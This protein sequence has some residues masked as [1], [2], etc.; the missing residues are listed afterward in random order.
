MNQK[1]EHQFLQAKPVWLKGRETEKNLILGF[2]KCFDKPQ[3]K[4]VVVKIAAATIYRAFLNGQFLGCG[5]ARAAHGFYRIDEWNLANKLKKGIN[6]LA[7]EVAGY[8]ANSYYLHY[9]QQL[10]LPAH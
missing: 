2:R 10:Q 5:P 8:N 9:S 1:N 6:V 4:E 7:I 3:A